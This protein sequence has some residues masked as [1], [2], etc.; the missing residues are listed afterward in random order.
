MRSTFAGLNTMVRGIFANQLSLDTV[1]HN[2]TNASTEGYTRQSVNLAATMCQLQGSMYGDVA[3]GTGVDSLSIIRARNTYA[4]RQYRIEAATQEYNNI[5]QVNYE[6][7]ETT[8]YDTETTGIQN[9]MHDFWKAWQALSVNASGTAERDNVIGKGKV[10]TDLIRS[11]KENLTQQI[12]ALHEE[13]TMRVDKINELT[14][15]IVQYNE[16]IVGIEASGSSA[17]DLRDQRDLAC[18]QLAKYIDI[19]VNEHPEGYYSI[20]SNGVS[21][22]SATVSLTLEVERGLK[23]GENLHNINYGS[24]DYGIRIKETNTVFDPRSGSL[25]G[26]F[27]A[28]DENKNMIDDLANVAA[29]ML[30]TFNAQHKAGYDLNGVEGGNFFGT[31]DTSYNGY[32]YSEYRYYSG[33]DD[34]D[35]FYIYKDDKVLTGIDIIDELAVNPKLTAYG[36]GQYIAAKTNRDSTGIDGTSTALDDNAV[37][38][39]NFFDMTRD[40]TE[41][42]SSAINDLYHY[43][44]NADGDQVDIFY[45][46]FVT[47]DGGATR[48]VVY[49]GDDGIV[50]KVTSS[51]DSDDDGGEVYYIDA[52]GTRLTISSDDSGDEEDG[53]VTFTGYRASTYSTVSYTT[54]SNGFLVYSSED[55]Q[56]YKTI[57]S[58]GTTGYYTYNDSG[59]QVALN[60]IS[61][62][63]DSDDDDD[64]GST[65]TS[66]DLIATYTSDEGGITFTV[67]SKGG[68]IRATGDVSI[69]TYYNYSMSQ[70]GLRAETMDLKVEAQ[71]ELIVQIENWRASEAG[72]DWN[73]ELTNMIRFQK[74]YGACARCLTAMDEMLDR[75]VNNTG[76][77]GR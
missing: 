66:S 19:T 73:E 60:R 18:D 39:S 61:A 24:D 67:S 29:L 75:L 63:S 58:D 77:V 49:R 4:D 41:L 17:N 65:T 23:Q 5:M 28:I 7:I 3:V 33:E 36:G 53:G 44:Y 71:D 12:D 8:F 10:L 22:L 30:T 54:S 70:L 13:L 1:G 40:Y 14:A 21:L 32:E 55:G 34:P 31:T 27:D 37:L 46:T 59:E 50:Y 11:A 52:Y 16:Q 74:G 42:T 2:I 68:A 69:Y 15:K 43:Y 51:S 62:G 47:I 35:Y 48:E 57:S 25:K 72:V 38:L 20:V 64:D 9:A 45:D 56:I 6:N 76:Q 26:V